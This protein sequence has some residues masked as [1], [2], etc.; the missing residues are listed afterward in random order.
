VLQE[1]TYW[2]SSIP[3]DELV[4]LLLPF[5][6]F[7]GTRYTIA[8][9]M[10][11]F[12]DALVSSAKFVFGIKEN[13]E[14]WSYC[15]SVAV[16]IVGL[17]EGE[18]IQSALESVYDT[19]PRMELFVVDDGSTDGMAEKAEEFAR[20]HR[21]VTVLSRKLRGGKSS[22]MNMPLPLIKSEIVVVI[23]SD[24]HLAPGA[25]WNIVQ[26]FKDPV[27][28]A[29][30]G[31][32]SARNPFENLCTILQAMEYRRSIFLGRI[33]L[34]RLDVLG[35]VS[36]AL[37]AFRMSA[38]QKFGG[39]DVGPGE[40]GD[41]TIK[42]RKAGYKIGYVPEAS[43]LTNVPTK[44]GTLTRQ[45][46]RWEWAAI[47]FECRKHIDAGNPFSKHFQF[48]NFIMMLER[49]TFNV[50]LV[51]ASLFYWFYLWTRF[52][53]D[54]IFRLGILFYLL[55]SICDVLQV[56]MLIYYSPNKWADVKL[57]MI[58]PFMP[59]YYAYQKIVTFIAITEE[60]IWR[61]SFQSNFVPERVRNATWHW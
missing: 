6:L 16:M 20:E 5:L 12:Y 31:S 1:W 4:W 55:Y 8:T 56:V 17:N 35:I 23:D 3:S 14:D 40:D 50:V 11:L 36:G 19:Y 58:S 43:C 39:W 37:G 18:T 57:S 29:V 44:F 34:A 33:L 32:V 24:S 26:P 27:V 47:T 42:F 28:G 10:M 49:W 45:R 51:Y 2:L 46:R 59:I 52:P 41:L 21:G 48:R 54:E 60:L 25:I 7:D 22:A 13:E 53:V 38:L 30:S 15:P 9:A 61:K